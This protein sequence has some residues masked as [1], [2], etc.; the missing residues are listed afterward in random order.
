MVLVNILYP[1]GQ[2]LIS[3]HCT[4]N[5][6]TVFKPSGA[7]G[8]PVTNQVVRTTPKRRS[9]NTGSVIKVHIPGAIAETFAHLFTS[10]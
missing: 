1:F 7:K 9:E 10:S 6:T 5:I 3:P 8:F 2:L 4:M